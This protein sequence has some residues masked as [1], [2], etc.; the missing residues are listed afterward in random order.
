MDTSDTKRIEHRSQALNSQ[1]E[2]MSG[3]E[4]SHPYAKSSFKMTATAV[5][6]MHAAG[7][8]GAA[9]DKSLG[10]DEEEAWA[11]VY[12]VM[13]DSNRPRDEWNISQVRAT[14]TNQAISMN[15]A[16]VISR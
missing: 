7:G 9:L 4:N 11:G 10:E 5:E 1:K 15:N 14:D 6:K 16:A 2:T 13:L 12:P 8:G 3:E